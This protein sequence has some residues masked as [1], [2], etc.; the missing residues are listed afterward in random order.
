MTLLTLALNGTNVEDLGLKPATSSG[1]HT[2]PQ[3]TYAKLVQPL[4][5]GFRVLSVSQTVAA[6]EL[7]LRFISYPSSFT[8]RQTRMDALAAQFAGT[9]SITTADAPD[10][11]CFGLLQTMPVSS[12]TG[13]PFVASYEAVYADCTI[14]C[15]DPL[16]YD[17]DPLVTAI[18]AA[19]AVALSMGTGPIRKMVITVDGAVTNPVLILRDQSGVEAQRMTLTGVIGAGQ[20]L[21]IDCDAYTITRSDGL[22]ALQAGWLGTGETFF[23][24]RPPFTYTLESATAVLSVS[25]FRSWEN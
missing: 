24:L 15:D 21:T 4:R 10:R 13:Y 14:V 5:R 25:H 20:W 12:A 16:F 7:A 22:N 23:E 8:D 3:R 17:T 1:W 2:I 6:R 18:P 19:T 11:E 9:V